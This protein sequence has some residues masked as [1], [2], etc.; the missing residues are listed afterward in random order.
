MDIIMTVLN[1]CVLS[2]DD[3]LGIITKFGTEMEAY[4]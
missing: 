3:V 4:E 1:S 2:V